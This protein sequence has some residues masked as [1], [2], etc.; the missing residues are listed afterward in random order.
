MKFR[1]PVALGAAVLA[2]SPLAACNGDSGTGAAATTTTSDVTT[3]TALSGVLTPTEAVLAGQCLNELPD[4]AQQPFAV[5]VVPCEESHTYE[6]YAQTK[7]DMGTP[8]P[9]GTAYPGALAVANAAEAQ[10]FAGFTAFM[11][12]QWE[13]SDYDIQTWWPSESSWSTKRD[14][15][16]LCAV[17]RVTG[18]RTKGS[19]RGSAK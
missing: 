2:C 3:T 19:V 14:R 1:F 12:I 7:I 8:T 17:Y 10:C 6:V 11:G 18:G 4:P 5:M 9:N 16:I 15:S 13:A